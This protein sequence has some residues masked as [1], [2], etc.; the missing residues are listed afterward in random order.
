MTSFNMI[1]TASAI[2]ESTKGELDE[3]LGF[4]IEWVWHTSALG[5]KDPYALFD[6]L[7]EA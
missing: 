3:T 2:I 1:P 7:G 5:K 4:T 6:Y